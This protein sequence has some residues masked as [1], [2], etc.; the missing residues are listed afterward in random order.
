M[1]SLLRIFKT[2]EM[3]AFFH[4]VRYFAGVDSAQTQTTQAE[5]DCLVRFAQGKKRCA[6]IGVFEGLTTGTIA[7]TL[8]EDAILYAIDPFLAGRTGICWGLPIAKREIARQRQKCKVELVRAFSS[9]AS[10]KVEG[11]F[12]FVF[13]DGDHS[14]A[15]ITQDWEDWSKRILPGGI[16]ALHDT[17]VPAHNPRVADFGSHTYFLEHIRHDIRFEVVEQV[18]SLSVLQRK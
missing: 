8:S 12:D 14:L 4:M 17:L 13:I 3:R 11:N 5:R 9:E 16:I 18:D 15:A 6:E 1:R 2:S 10:N 7:R